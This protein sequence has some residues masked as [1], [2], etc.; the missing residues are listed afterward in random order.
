VKR[1]DILGEDCKPVATGGTPDGVA[2][3]DV[4]AA[5]ETRVIT[6]ALTGEFNANAMTTGDAKTPLEWAKE[7]RKLSIFVRRPAP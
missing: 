4:S 2:L 7:L 6:V 5:K 3:E 1:G